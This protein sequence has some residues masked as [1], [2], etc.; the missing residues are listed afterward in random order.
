[1][2]S[3]K[4]KF[5]LIFIILSF[6]SI[7]TWAQLEN[8]ENSEAPDPMLI[9][10]IEI[11]KRYFYGE[12]QWY[13]S[14]PSFAKDVKGLIDFVENEPVDTVISNLNKSLGEN[15]RY[16][17]RLPEDVEDSL[18]VTGFYPNNLVLQD[19]E[20]TRIRLKDRF[21]KSPPEVPESVL[22][23]AEQRVELIPEGEGM[24][25]FVD[26]VYKMPARLQIPEVIPDSLLSSPEKFAELVQKDSLR[27]VYIEQ[28]RMNYNDSILAAS[29]ET[30]KSNYWNQKY[31]EELQYQS[32][33]LRDSVKV[34][35]FNVL[36]SYNEMVVNAVNDS[37]LL[38]LQTLSDYADFIDSTEISIVNLSGRS[39][40]I[41]LKNGDERFARVWLK[42]VQEDSLSVI[43]KS[44][45]KR[46][47]YMVIDDGVTI[48]HYKPK[49][50]KEFDF[51]SLGKSITSLTDVGKS[52]EIRTPWILGGNGN[53]GFSQTHQ[54]NWKKG[55]QSALSSIIVLKGYAKYTRAD[56]KVRWDNTGEF[57]N[58]WIRPG[59][60]DAE[61][62]KNDDKI[63]FTSRFGV[64][65]FKKWFYSSEL[66]YETQFFR[67]YKYPT[68]DRPTPISAFMSPA[69]TFYKVGMEYKPN[70]L[71]SML[72][73]PLTLKHVYVRDTAL[74]DQTKFG[75]EPG[76][77]SFSEPGLNADLNYKR[78]LATNI[79]YET[80]YKMF[81][82]YK[83]PFRKFD[84]N[85]EN[86]FEMKLN[87]HINLRFL[88]HMIYDD[89][90]LFPIYDKDDNKIGEKPKLQIKEYFSIGFSYSLNH[91]V[92][93]SK[94]I[95]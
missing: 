66:N 53:I 25:L 38:V 24:K 81:I 64:S 47:M 61:M 3:G 50:T 60:E 5:T 89:R 86:L 83:D 65:A 91:K 15:T 43:V 84:I 80:R 7:Q 4:I 72:L 12:N 26:S 69:R 39:S 27:T 92:M 52:Y 35:N 75:I 21:Q 93:K 18:E 95:R 41:L 85:W 57:R 48:S 14:K 76:K 30:A 67:G 6:L 79:T 77:K 49:Q 31:E 68:A 46:T 63:E 94:R 42:N 16:V 37:I 29:I 59:G 55:G 44:V 73:S 23:N 70:N 87:D 22:A 11:L 1:M 17:F 33:R 82:N 2:D 34:N 13:I 51:S 40:D 78:T 36:R 54:E 9:K 19:I 8:P 62:Q 20:N 28:K 71:F 32:K 90:V 45:D 88:L 74:I 56:G 10:S 58:G